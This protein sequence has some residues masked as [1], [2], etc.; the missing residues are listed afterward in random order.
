MF[1]PKKSLNRLKPIFTMGIHNLNNNNSNNNKKPLGHTVNIG[2]ATSF[3]AW[4]TSRQV[5]VI[6]LE[7]IKAGSAVP[8]E[9]RCP[10]LIGF[11]P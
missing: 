5:V 4:K 9:V 6:L 8:R 11:T 10:S 2:L 7:R 3:T 1:T